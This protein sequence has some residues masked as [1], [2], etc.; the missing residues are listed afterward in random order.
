MLSA[1]GIM[2]ACRSWRS[3]RRSPAFTSML[4]SSSSDAR[5]QA[6]WSA[7]VIVNTGPPLPPTSGW[8]FKTR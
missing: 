5:I 4:D 8:S 3:S 2:S 6:A 7:A 1:D